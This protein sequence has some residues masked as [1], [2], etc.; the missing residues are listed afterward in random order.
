MARPPRIVA[1]GAPNHVILR[2]NN[3]R[4][5]F[6]G[7][8]DIRLLLF[9]LGLALEDC[10]GN[11]ALHALC[12][13][14]NHLHLIATPRDPPSLS[15][16]VKR[17]SQRYAQARNRACGATGKLFEQRYVSIPIAD[18]R[19]LAV[20][21]AYIELNPVRA[22]MVDTPGEYPWSTYALHAGERSAI[23]PSL[24]TPS[25]WYES[26]SLDP[27]VRAT[28]YVEWMRWCIERDERPGDI[29]LIGKAE[30][31]T[32]PARRRFQRPDGTSVL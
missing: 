32:V 26:L 27:V 24:W 10:D 31:H 15:N 17:F 1:S 29:D 12:V 3:R 20:T 6:S 21:T 5:L 2:G 22:G 30:A 11:C 25:T 7:V 8:P 23:S 28:E 16:F 14:T 9:L 19:Q 13:M 18:E 4:R